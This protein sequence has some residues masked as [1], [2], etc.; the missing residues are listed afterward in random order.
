MAGSK[1]SDAFE[2]QLKAAP[3]GPTTGDTAPPTA[4]TADRPPGANGATVQATP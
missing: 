3:L 2:V 1:L 4:A